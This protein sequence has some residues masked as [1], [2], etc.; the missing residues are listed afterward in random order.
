MAT[1]DNPHQPSDLPPSGRT[2]V[3]TGSSG[4]IGREVAIQLAAG[5]FSSLVLHHATNASAA[6]QTARQVQAHGCRAF[7]LQ[8]DCSI[9]AD[10]QRLVD[11]AFQT[12][13]VPDVWVHVAGVDVLTGPNADLSFDQ[14]LQQLIAVDL[15][16][17]ITVAR[18]VVSRWEQGP[19][20]S[21]PPSLILIGWDQAT[22]GMEGEAGQLFGPIKAAVEAFGKSLA[23]SV[24][25]RIRVNTV[26][27]GW[28]R[29][30]W[31][32]TTNDYWD[33]RARGQA[34]MGRWGTPR[35]VAAAVCFLA[36]PASQ[37]MTGQTIAVNGGFSRRWERLASD[38]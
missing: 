38:A 5:G 33:R 37:F 2:G 13:G 30:A 4:G 21:T 18:A 8:A 31:G 25:P 27:P 22:E 16:G 32:E 29:T 12:L 19:A 26:A 24:A 7:S 11:A 17:T 6:E 3:V 14:K 15:V 1:A 36:D 28:I 20:G 9:L 23:Q 10:C 35:D 34:L